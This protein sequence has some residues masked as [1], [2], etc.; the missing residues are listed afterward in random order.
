MGRI[1]DISMGYDCNAW[2]DYCTITPLMR[3]RELSTKAIKAELRLGQ[4][5]SAG[6]RPYTQVRFGGGEPTIRADLPTL[7]REARLLG[8]R[9]IEVQSNGL[10][11]ANADYVS[12]LEKAGV[13]S[14]AISVMSHLPE[15]YESITGVPRSRDLVLAGIAHILRLGTT[16]PRARAPHLT[17]DVIMKRDT[18]RHLPALVE[19]YVA[20]GVKAFV[21][22]LVSLS[23]RN[24]AFPDSLVP[25]REMRPSIETACR[26]G[27]ERGA[28]VRSRHIPRCML[29]SLGEEHFELTLFE[30]VTVVTPEERFELRD[31]LIS[32]NRYLPVCERCRARARCAG[33]RADYLDHVGA[34]EVVPLP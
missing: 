4:S 3:G 13:T 16:A 27:R 25:V 33:V 20:R 12:A 5:A 23:D 26:I 2:C 32:A 34:S 22:W 15:L 1:L 6:G 28:S 24:A 19:F 8:Y 14:F 30:A 7:I 10:R 31:S 21:L 9:E 18:Y 17:A 11:Y 29:P